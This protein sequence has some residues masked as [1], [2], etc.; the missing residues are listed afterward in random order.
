[1]TKIPPEIQ[2]TFQVLWLDVSQNHK[3][4][5][6]FWLA[7]FTVNVI[8]QFWWASEYVI[9]RWPQRS[10]QTDFHWVPRNKSDQTICSNPTM[11]WEAWI[12]I[13]AMQYSSN[14]TKGL[15]VVLTLN[16]V[17]KCTITDKHFIL[18][19]SSGSLVLV[20]VFIGQSIWVK[21]ITFLPCSYVDGFNAIFVFC[22][23]QCD[24]IISVKM[25]H[26]ILHNYFAIF[27]FFFSS[28]FFRILFLCRA[29]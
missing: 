7:R 8:G 12:V 25:L 16:Q 22:C 20:V 15:Q 24:T 29:A 4:L 27:F 1:M 10:C 11:L 3:T 9:G 28:Y 2:G 19:F 17:S 6:H 26:S 21:V 18:V 5:Q 14:P 13:S 23:R